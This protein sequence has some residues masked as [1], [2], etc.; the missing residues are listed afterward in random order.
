MGAHGGPAKLPRR[1]PPSSR[2][3]VDGYLTPLSAQVK[4]ELGP[5]CNNLVGQLDRLPDSDKSQIAKM[6]DGRLMDVPQIQNLIRVAWRQANGDLPDGFYTL[7]RQ[8]HEVCISRFLLLY[9]N[10]SPSFDRAISVNSPASGCRFGGA[11]L[12]PSPASRKPSN[13]TVINVFL[14][15]LRDRLDALSF[16][17]ACDV[18]NAV[19]TKRRRL[20]RAAFRDLG[21][22]R[23]RM[24]IPTRDDFLKDYTTQINDFFGI[25]HAL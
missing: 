16:D 15:F 4:S 24:T 3:F 12:S 1:E 18:I 14:G 10:H 21:L 23:C 2:P 9:L 13:D 17:N 5:F 7:F 11:W 20:I 19:L 25:L 8:T 6:D 22:K